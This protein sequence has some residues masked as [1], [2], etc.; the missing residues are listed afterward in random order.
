MNQSFELKAEKRV[1]VGTAPS[2]RMRKEGKIPA[3]VYGGGLTSMDVTINHNAVLRSLENEAFY[4]HVLSLDVDGKKEEVLLKDVHRHP[5]GTHILHLDFLRVG[6]DSKIRKLVP[7]HFI[8]EDVAPGVKKGGQLTHLMNSVELVCLVKDLP[9]FVEIDLSNL[10]LGETFHL[11]DIKLPN[12]MKIAALLQGDDHDL[13]VAAIHKPRGA[14]SDDDT[15]TE[16]A[17]E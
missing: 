11:K 15:A 4:S 12:G 13:P 17:A 8:G 2:R 7:I 3:V 10:G 5:N 9:E 6:G 1:N 14:S 16:P